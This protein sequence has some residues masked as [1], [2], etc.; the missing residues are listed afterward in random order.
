MLRP[1]VAFAPLLERVHRAAQA[2]KQHHRA[3]DD[4]HD[5]EQRQR[6]GGHGAGAAAPAEPEEAA[7]ALATLRGEHR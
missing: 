4:E 2:R 7:V 1:L 5:A 6:V 3:R